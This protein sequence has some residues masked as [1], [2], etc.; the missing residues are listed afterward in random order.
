MRRL[1]AGPGRSPGRRLLCLGAA[2][3]F[4]AACEPDPGT[5]LSPVSRS[6]QPPPDPT[7]L[8]FDVGAPP[9]QHP[10]TSFVAIAGERMTFRVFFEGGRGSERFLDLDL[11]DGSLYRYPAGY[12][13]DGVLFFAPGDTITITVSIDSLTLSVELGPE[14]LQFS[15]DKPARLELGYLFADPDL[16]GQGGADPQLVPSIRMFRQATD[17]A[18]WEPLDSENDLLDNRV[19]FDELV[20]FSRYALAI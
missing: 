17:G 9:I 8:Q 16:D 13:S 2:L 3:A 1:E 5:L 7:L 11:H 19:K 4:V 15:E 6:A 12:R 20:K 10:D 14:G 18:D